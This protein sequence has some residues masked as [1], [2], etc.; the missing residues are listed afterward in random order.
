MAMAQ[1]PKAPSASS[2]RPPTAC[3]LPTT[4]TEHGADG[5]GRN[6]SQRSGVHVLV[7]S[8]HGGC[9]GNFNHPSPAW[10]GQNQIR[11]AVVWLA[12]TAL[13]MSKGSCPGVRKRAAPGV[14]HDMH[15]GKL[16]R[17]PASPSRRVGDGFTVRGFAGSLGKSPKHCGNITKLPNMSVLDPESGKS[18]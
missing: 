11:V 8:C 1:G 14:I 3:P 5:K 9:P 16:P 7:R 13:F 6:D 4:S 10:P 17:R 18:C 12:V 15:A 2:A